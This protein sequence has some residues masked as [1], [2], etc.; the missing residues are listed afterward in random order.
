MQEKEE[1]FGP[2]LLMEK[3]SVL[4]EYL[5]REKAKFIQISNEIENSGKREDNTNK[6]AV[7]DR[8]LLID[9]ALTF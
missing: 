8:L 3:N 6:E 5:Q 4:L 2:C 7:K 1:W 9:S